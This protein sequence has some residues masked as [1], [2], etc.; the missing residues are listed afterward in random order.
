MTRFSAD[1][2]DAEIINGI[3]QWVD[4]L[5]NDDYEAAYAMLQHAPDEPWTADFLRR[6]IANY[7]RHE[8]LKDGATFHVTHWETATGRETHY[9]DVTRRDAPHMN[10]SVGDV[11]YD[12]PLNGE[13][14]DLTAIFD[15]LKN[16]GALVLQLDDVHVL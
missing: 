16:D 7:G 3:R 8:A 11:H 9:Q 4:A 13:W 14:S 1:A 12:L 15:I 5:A 2:S 6:W 10:G